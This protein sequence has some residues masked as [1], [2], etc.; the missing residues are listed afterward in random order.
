MKKSLILLGALTSKPY[1]FKAR[2]WELKSI[3]TID[4]FDSLGSNIR[5][6]VRGS[7]IMRVLPISNE[8]INEEWISDKA[9]F[10][11]DGLKRDRFINPMIKSNGV[12]IQSTWKEAFNF[13]E[14]QITEKQINNLVINTG[15]FTDLEHL[16]TLNLLSKKIDNKFNVSINNNQNINADFQEYYTLNP[17]LF[18]FKGKKVFL[19]VGINL[20]LENPVLNIKFKKLS[21]NNNV[22]I[23]YIGSRYDYNINLIHL[24]NNISTFTKIVEGRHYFSTIISNFLKTNTK[25]EKIQNNLKN[26]ISVIFG[27][28]SIQTNQHTKLISSIKELNLNSPKFDF[29]VLEMYSGKINALEVGFFN[30][31]KFSKNTKKVF[32]LLNTE[33]LT[34]KGKDDFIIFQGH[35]NYKN[36]LEFDVI[37]PSVT[38]TEKSAMYLNCFG[39][40]QKTQFVNLPPANCRIDWKISVMLLNLLSKNS[41]LNQNSNSYL[42]NIHIE[43]NKLTPN[44]MNLLSIYKVK[45]VKPLNIKYSNNIKFNNI[46]NFM[47]FKSF[48]SNYYKISSIEKVSKIMTKC[49]EAFNQKKSNFLK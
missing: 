11:Y 29:N 16:T 15:N 25:G 18:N 20:R 5:I 27:N 3:E 6:D 4:L 44:I 7:E 28:E 23:G 1:A 46:T 26:S 47:P 17:N 39:F 22:L 43:L 12:F 19:L 42:N 33:N 13:I 9:R 21:N 37:L 24:G 34:N 2:S 35:H 31:V 30:N 48:I 36:R 10:A 49:T 41:E 32:Y 45:S 38:W 40:V 8:Y 14:K